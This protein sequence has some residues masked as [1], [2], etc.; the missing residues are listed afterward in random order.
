MKTVSAEFAAALASDTT[1]FCT[2]F[3][4]ERRDG[5][6]FAATDLDRDVIF[7]DVTYLADS[8]YTITDIE[9]GSDLNADNLD[10]QGFLQSPSITESD[11]RAG[12]WD[13]AFYRI[14]MVN[15]QD[16]TMGKMTERAGHLGEVTVK[17]GQFVAELRGMIDL[18]RKTLGR[19]EGAACN[20]IFGDSR[21][22]KDLTGITVTGTVEG[23][24]ADNLTIYD[25]A[26]VEAGPAGSIA[27][28]N[29][30]SAN[31]AVVTLA[32]TPD[33]VLFEGELITIA[34]VL[35][36]T[37][38]NVVTV[39]HSPSGTTFNLDIDTSDT[40]VFPTYIS[41]GT[42]T[43]FGDDAGYFGNGKIT[44]VTGLNADITRD[45]KSYVEGQITLHEPF[46]FTVAI[47]D[48]YSLVPGCNKSLTQC[49]DTWNNI[50]NFR[51][52]P[53]L[54]GLD[55]LQQVGRRT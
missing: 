18:Y 47:G 20:A 14:F 19:M 48:T 15:Y 52:M 46:P 36:P 39:V 33:P 28:S 31:P 43:P 9:S 17:R 53:Y 55:R 27:I 34:G 44:M 29:I 13:Y 54:P 1:T 50:V 51:G 5:V 24:N 10:I 12:R 32:T 40:A 2:M 30:T 42:V 38:L 4:V 23:I 16:L 45:V 11:L 49:R 41:G 8:G 7:E 22:K 37:A 25:S 26:R 3:Y 35:G 6:I 21:C